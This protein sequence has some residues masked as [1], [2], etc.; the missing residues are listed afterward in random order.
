ME[1]TESLLPQPHSP[2]HFAKSTESLRKVSGVA[3]A[4]W[5]SHTSPSEPDGSGFA[6]GRSGG[7]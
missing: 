1:E 3:K 5:S 4:G 7:A 6:T 2:M